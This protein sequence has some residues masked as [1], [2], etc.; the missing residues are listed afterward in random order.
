VP[1]AIAECRLQLYVDAAFEGWR[2]VPV[3]S[4]GARI[5]SARTGWWDESLSRTR[6]HVPQASLGRHEPNVQRGGEIGG[7]ANRDGRNSSGGRNSIPVVPEP[8]Q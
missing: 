6:R 3:R 8:L 5:G 4:H 7:G 1:V 2:T